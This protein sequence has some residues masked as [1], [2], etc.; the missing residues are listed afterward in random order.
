MCL[1]IEGR[2]CT[3]AQKTIGDMGQD[4]PGCQ[5]LSWPPQHSPSSC[6]ADCQSAPPG[7]FPSDSFLQPLSLMPVAL[8]GV[9]IIQGQD[10]SLYLHEPH[11]AGLN[12]SIQPVQIL[13]Q[14]LSALQKINTSAQ[15]GVICRLTVGGYL[16]PCPNN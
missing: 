4:Q 16:F 2:I 6:S 9:V 8:H 15:F 3:S 11:R 13:L 12:L 10:P 14:S 5:W 7:P 1:S